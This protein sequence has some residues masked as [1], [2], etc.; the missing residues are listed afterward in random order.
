MGKFPLLMLNAVRRG[1]A[2]Y[3]CEGSFV[4]GLFIPY[5]PLVSVSRWGG[6]GRTAARWYIQIFG[7][8][9]ITQ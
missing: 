6:G 9:P 8:F 7:A 4:C 3:S 2:S 1:C 5:L